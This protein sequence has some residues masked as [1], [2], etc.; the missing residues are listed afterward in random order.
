MANIL[1][2]KSFQHN[3]FKKIL[4]DELWNK[5]GIFTTIHV[6]GKPRNF[7]FLK[8]HLCKLNQSLQFFSINF[9]IDNT[10]FNIVE[11]NLFKKNIYYDHLFRIAINNKKISFSL[12][13]K[14]KIKN[15]FTG[16][17]VTYQRPKW[18]LKHLQYN[19]VIKFLNKINSNYEEIILT[20]NNFIYEGATTNIIFVKNNIIYL[21]KNGFYFGITLKFLLKKNKRRTIK[22]NI[23]IDQL[24]DYDEILLVGTGKGV[25]YVE[26]IPQIN[27]YMRKITIFNEFQRIY[28]SYIIKKIAI[29]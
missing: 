27:W 15:N 9:K 12:R 8:E 14:V 16:V 6:L 26:K 25:V 3:I 7:L 22:K 18:R 1:F 21:P 17:L 2:K 19:K 10:L 29:K 13:K 5:K 4:F 24:H 28:K 23:K 11:K 20:K